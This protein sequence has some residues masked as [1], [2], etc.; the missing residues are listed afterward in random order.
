MDVEIDDGEPDEGGRDKC[1]RQHEA[2]PRT[3]PHLHRRTHEHDGERRC[4]QPHDVEACER[5]RAVGDALTMACG[6]DLARTERQRTD[7]EERDTGHGQQHASIMSAQQAS[8]AVADRAVSR[9]R[10]ETGDET[11]R[12][13]PAK[14]ARV[15]APPRAAAHTPRG[16]RGRRTPS[17]PAGPG[18]SSRDRRA[19]RGAD[20]R[21]R[22]RTST[23]PCRA[24]N[25]P[26][27]P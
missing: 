14:R 11:G 21:G 26:P 25:R 13:G 5:R 8:G 20:G 1:E 9:A 19:P 16:H 2:G 23:G 12:V 6:D 4:C 27:R 10:H 3:P 18:T 22:R 7:E 15:T 17:S 24:A